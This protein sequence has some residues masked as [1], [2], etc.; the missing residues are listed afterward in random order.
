M[1]TIEILGELAEGDMFFIDIK[2]FKY[3]YPKITFDEW[4]P[5]FLE[6]IF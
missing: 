5:L 4:A 1:L 6:G 2:M 3:S